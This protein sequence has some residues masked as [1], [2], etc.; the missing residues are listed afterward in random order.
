MPG[1]TRRSRVLGDTATSAYSVPSVSEPTAITIG[2]FDGAHVGHA[3]LLSAA[4]QRVGAGGRVVA[5]SFDPHPMEVLQVHPPPT[6]LTTWAHREELLRDAGADEVVR[7]TPT[8]SLLSQAP[9]AFCRSLVADYS[10]TAIVEGRDFRFGRGRTGDVQTLAQIGA[11]MGFAVI[12]V[13]PVEV[14][15]T[16][17]FLVPASSS[18]ARWLLRNGRVR[19]AAIVLGRSY[20]LRSTTERGAQR[21]RDLGFPT[22]NLADT[23]C[24]LPADGIYAGRANVSRDDAERTFPAAIS[25]GTNPTFGERLRRCEAHLIGYDGELDHYGGRIELLFDDWLR[26]QLRYDTVDDLVDQLHRDVDCVTERYAVST[27][28]P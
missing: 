3:V 14:S 17:Q 6:R 13:D 18:M 23:P 21:G 19:D 26:D 15:L 27:C 8:K 9:E 22:M 5:M 12:V 28:Q 1:E 4:R 20:A 10:P 2:N 16:D 25:I 24:L 11:D 7:L